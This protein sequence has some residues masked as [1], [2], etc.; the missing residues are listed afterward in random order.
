MGIVTNIKSANT[1]F[2]GLQPCSPPGFSCSWLPAPS[3]EPQWRSH[4][5]LSGGLQWD[6]PVQLLSLWQR[7]KWSQPCCSHGFVTA[8]SQ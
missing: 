4:G 1:V 6:I 2:R 7:Q 3:T 8:G 5:A